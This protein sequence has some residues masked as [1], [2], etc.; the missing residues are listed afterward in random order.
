MKHKHLSITEALP[1]PGRR[2][3]LK[4]GFAIGPASVA[5]VA[6]AALAP[7][8]TGTSTAAGTVVALSGPT[9]SPSTT[10]FLEAMPITPL[11]PERPLT[12]PAFKQVPTVA[13]NRV[14]N[15][16]TGIP[17]RIHAWMKAAGGLDGSGATNFDAPLSMNE[18]QELIDQR[19][20]ASSVATV[21][22]GSC[23]G[24]HANLSQATWPQTG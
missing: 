7:G 1:S 20:L 5:G 22:V 24:D 13:P 11:L 21:R 6:E 3:A 2:T 15:P 12:D 23:C 14:R 4:V 18:R 16:S 9:P 10:P 19:D 17:Q 8:T